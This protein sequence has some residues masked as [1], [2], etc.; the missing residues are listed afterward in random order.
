MKN[1]TKTFLVSF[2][3]VTL[4]PKPTQKERLCFNIHYQ[5]TGHH[6]AWSRNHRGILLPCLLSGCPGGRKGRRVML[7]SIP[8][9]SLAAAQLAFLYSP[10][11]PACLGL[12]WPLAD[13][14]LQ[15]QLTTKTIPPQTCHKPVWS[16]QFLHRLSSQMTLVY[17]KLITEAKTE[18][19]INYY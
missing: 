9:C 12:L 11:L 5:N 1:I 2:G 6:W 15:R 10:G 8:A 18:A 3:L 4:W 17:V 16:G 19:Q 7:S 13:W 14:T